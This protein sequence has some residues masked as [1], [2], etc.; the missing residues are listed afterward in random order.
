MKKYVQPEMELLFLGQ[1][2]I[3]TQSDPFDDDIFDDL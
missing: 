2:D 3:L 1:N